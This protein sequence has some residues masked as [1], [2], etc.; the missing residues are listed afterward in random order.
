MNKTLSNTSTAI[1]SLLLLVG[2][3]QS[4]QERVPPK[5][6]KPQT[7]LRFTEHPIMDGYSYPFGIAAADLDADGDLDLT[8]ADGTGHEKLYWFQNDGLGSFKRYL[9]QEKDPVRLERH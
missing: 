9:I 5:G 8:S 2:C 3:V 6:E 7:E 1:G 4:D